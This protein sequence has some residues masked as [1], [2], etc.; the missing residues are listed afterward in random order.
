MA[1]HSVPNIFY[2][3]RKSMSDRERR[4]ALKLLCQIVKIE[5]ID[6]VKI[7]SAIDNKEFF[8]L[9]DCLQEE[10]AMAVSAD[11]IVTRNI[12]DFKNS[13]APAILPD[14]FLDRFLRNNGGKKEW[15]IWKAINNGAATLI[16]M[17]IQKRSLR[18]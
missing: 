13:K 10:C 15:I 16:L 6:A 7:I 2:I 8:D 11:Y 1:A 12:K 17:K 18:P 9:E 3:L 4:E 5:G 14:V